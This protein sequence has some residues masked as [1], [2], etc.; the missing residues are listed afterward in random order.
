[1]NRPALASAFLSLVTTAALVVSGAAVSATASATQDDTESSSA[2]QDETTSDASQGGPRREARR[3]DRVPTPDPEWFDCT[4]AF[5]DGNECTTVELPLD[6]DRHKGRTTSVAVLRHPAADQSTKLGTLFVNPGGPGASGV[7]MAAVAPFF[8]GAE[9]LDRFDIVGFD[10]RGTN[11][12]DN[13]RCWEHMGT[14][15]VDIRGFIEMPFPFTEDEENRFVASSEAIGRACASF[16]DRLVG[17]MSTAEVA[18][19]MDVLR[20]MVGDEQLTYLGFSYGSYL[21]TVY[22]N[23]FPGRVRAVAIDGI[24][25]PREWA[26]T[27]ETSDVPVTERIRSAEGSW[28]AFREILDRCEEAGPDFCQLA[29][30]GDPTDIATEV[31]ERLQNEPLVLTDPFT[32]QD[33]EITYA[34]FV[35]FLL[36]DMYFPQGPLFVDLD[37]S[38]AYSLLQ[39]QGAPGTVEG[40][41]SDAARSALLE[42]ARAVKKQ[43]TSAQQPASG[44][45]GFGFPY[46]N[47]LEAFLTVQCTDSTNPDDADSWRAHADRADAAAPH[48]GRLWTWQS[49]PCASDTWTVRDEDAYTGPFTRRTQN[50]VLVVGNLWDP[51][52]NYDNAVATAALLPGSRLLSSDSWGHTA[53]GTSA[54]VTDAVDA[55]LLSVRLP[56]PG[57]LCVGNDQ[58]FTIPIEAPPEPPQDQRRADVPDRL[59]PVVP[60]LPGAVPRG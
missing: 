58:P 51:A 10:P 50:P 44:G 48:F 12:S 43:T 26:G 28:R 34:I 27:A 47:S 45:F 22:A 25:D 21:G 36:G 39:E 15:V 41:V 52:T 29:G 46:D 14:Q 53:Y 54:C 23:L 31:L 19:D 7:V 13:V 3:V 55:Y 6:Y 59:P 40:S 49:A 60:P 37:L 16:G 17:S 24:L 18:R 35:S 4:L 1:M 20:R 11:F 57:T 33:I 5:G 42:K 8:L 30:I 32:G 56:E 2:T 9:V 38:F